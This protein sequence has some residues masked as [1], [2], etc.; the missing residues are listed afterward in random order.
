MPY[1]TAKPEDPIARW[2]FRFFVLQ[3]FS[4]SIEQRQSYSSRLLCL[5]LVL[6]FE[7]AGDI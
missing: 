2:I 7:I 1:E 5:I 4:L 6:E 3:P